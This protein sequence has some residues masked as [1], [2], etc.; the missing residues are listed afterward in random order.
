MKKLIH[1]VLAI[2][3]AFSMC[4]CDKNAVITD[5]KLTKE[6]TLYFS[7]TDYNDIQAE[8]RVITYEDEKQFPRAVVN[9][10]VKGPTE[11]GIKAVIPEGTQ[12]LDIRHDGAIAKLDFSREYFN[13][14]GDNSKSAELLARYSIVKT[15]CALDGIDKVLISVEGSELLNASGNPLGPIGESDIVFSQTQ[16]ENVTEKYVTLYFADEMGEKLV[17]RRRRV[18]IVDNSIEKTIVTEL[19]AGPSSDDGVYST[20]PSGTKVLSVETKEGIC[21]VNFSGEFISKFDGGSSAATMAIYSVVNSLTEL[22][23]ID[24]VQFLIDSAKTDT[25][26]DYFFSEPFERDDSLID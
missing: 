13:F 14:E 2:I 11:V 18:P 21:F 15:M 7:N 12:L 23:D 26:G 16:Q 5:S 4:S 25:F 6:V 22:P 19:V 10:L 9:E 3:I 1:F 24:K 8:K 17:A 20:I